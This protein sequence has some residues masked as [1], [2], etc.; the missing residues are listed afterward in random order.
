MIDRSL[1]FS[2]CENQIEQ[3]WTIWPISVDRDG[4]EIGPT[5]LFDCHVG[6]SLIFLLLCCLIKN[7]DD[8]D[9]HST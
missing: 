1:I 2:Q 3:N 9:H 6:T 8:D 5:R 4:D 7:T